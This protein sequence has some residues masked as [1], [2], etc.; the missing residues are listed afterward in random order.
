MSGEPP[1]EL[2]ER[3]RRDL[4]VV[5]WGIIVPHGRREYER[6]LRECDEILGRCYAEVLK[7]L[8]GNAVAAA[9]LFE[10]FAAQ[11]VKQTVPPKPKGRR[12]NR[13]R[14]ERLL[15]AYDA[16]SE[17]QRQAA[18]A[19]AAGAKTARDIDAAWKQTQRLVA[20]RAEWQKGRTKF[21]GL[22]QGFYETLRARQ[23]VDK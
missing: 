8:G 17:G 12:A 20:R 16:A 15:A 6:R 1:E 18:V 21:I 5:G 7:T 13:E 23:A 2:L 14:D 10:S 9:K 4:A 11:V 19:A 3:A 22:M